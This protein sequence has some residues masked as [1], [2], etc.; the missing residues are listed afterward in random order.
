MR[1]RVMMRESGFLQQQ[2]VDRVSE[3]NNILARAQLEDFAIVNE[4]RSLTDVAREMLIKAG[5]LAL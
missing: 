4:N 3:L 5:W 1:Q 2:F